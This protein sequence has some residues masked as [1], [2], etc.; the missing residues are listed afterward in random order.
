MSSSLNQTIRPFTIG[1]RLLAGVNWRSFQV[2]LL[3]SSMLF[4]TAKSLHLYQLL[5]NPFLESA[6]TA[7]Q[8]ALGSSDIGNGFLKS[9]EWGWRKMLKPQQARTLSDTSKP[10][11]DSTDVISILHSGTQLYWSNK[12]PCPLSPSD[13]KPL[14]PQWQVSYLPP[15]AT[16]WPSVCLIK[17]IPARTM[18][19]KQTSKSQ[20]S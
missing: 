1:N 12:Q 9:A 10:M 18:S 7:H 19:F 13:P 16:I 8:N 11:A 14:V 17:T 6:W 4:C 2:G 15:Q 3:I 5:A 20:I